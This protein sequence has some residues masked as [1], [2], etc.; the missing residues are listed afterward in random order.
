MATNPEDLFDSP[1]YT[2]YNQY[3]GNPYYGSTIDQYLFSDNEIIGNPEKQAISNNIQ[4]IIHTITSI[5]VLLWINIFSQT[6][7]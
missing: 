1:Y 5:T 6:L 7:R 4:Y 2:V 3:G